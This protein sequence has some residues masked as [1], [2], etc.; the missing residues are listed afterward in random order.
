MTPL[1]LAFVNSDDSLWWLLSD[2]FIDFFFLIDII[3]N[4]FTVY[5]NHLEDYE[6]S[7]KKIALNYLKKWFIFD[8][9]AILPINYFV[10]F[11]LGG[12]N[13]L[14]RMA[15]LPK[16]YKLIKIFRLVK[17]FR[18]VKQGGKIKKHVDEMLQI[19]IIIERVA[20]F[21]AILIV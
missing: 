9:I 17:V 2:S 6:I 14:A 11:G 3:L 5:V 19:G 16:L 8:V 4:F 13:D 10:D 15:R 12:F 1:R 21:V 20:T 18:L 7:R